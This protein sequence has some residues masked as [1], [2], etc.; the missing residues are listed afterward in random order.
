MYAID[1]TPETRRENNEQLESV[2]AHSHR[3]EE[4][5][6]DSSYKKSTKKMDNATVYLCIYRSEAYWEG[7][8]SVVDK[9]LKKISSEVAKRDALK[10]NIS[11]HVKGFGWK[12]IY[13]TWTHQR[14]KRP[15]SELAGKL[16]EI[17]K[18]KNMISTT[19]LE[20]RA[21]D[22]EYRM[23]VPILGTMSG[24]RKKT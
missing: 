18:Y 21:A 13:I 2:R 24:K 15:L 14:V 20:K 11:I 16:K 17:I 5:L 1:G 6:M 23:K 10:K 19:I 22:I 12:N 8:P 4:L 7:S 9:N 3:A